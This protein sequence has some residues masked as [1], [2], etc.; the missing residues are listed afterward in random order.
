MLTE[1][2]LLNCKESFAENELDFFNIT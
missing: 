1:S 2:R